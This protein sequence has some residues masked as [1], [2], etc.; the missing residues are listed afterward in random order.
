MKIGFDAKRAFHNTTGLGNYSRTLIDNIIMQYPDHEYLL[1]NTKSSDQTWG[2]NYRQVLPTGIWQSLPRALWRTAGITR[3]TS[4]SSL[5]VYHGLSHEL[6]YGIHLAKCKKIVT[7]H[8]LIFLK[9][10]ESFPLMDRLSYKSKIKYAVKVADEIV[11]ISEQTRQDLIE[12]LGVDEKKIK[13]VYQSCHPDYFTNTTSEKDKYLLYV[14]AFRERKNVLNII[15]AFADIKDE[16][17]EFRLILAGGG[18]SQ[19]ERQMRD[20]I[21]TSNLRDRVEIILS[22]KFEKL[23]ELYKKAYLFVYP[24]LY[25]GFGIPVIEALFSKTP[26]ISS[27]NTCLSE[28]GGKGAIYIDPYSVAKLSWA[29]KRVLQNRDVHQEL[30][31]AGY[32]HVQQFNCRNTAASLMELYLK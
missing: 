18:S 20:L 29:M 12:L 25:E 23:K 9:N 14:G 21:V 7:I 32:E 4:F 3:D 16:C 30:V 28:A 5:D 1:Y 11:A 17:P 10:V 24:S 26:V 27:S 19:Y 22:P 15:R 2:A 6:P 13:V 8:D 31:S